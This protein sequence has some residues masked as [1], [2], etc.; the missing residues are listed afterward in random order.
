MMAI[1]VMSAAPMPTYLREGGREGGREWVSEE[2]SGGR[3]EEKEGG[4]AYLP[5]EVGHVVQLFLWEK[6]GGEKRLIRQPREGGMEGGREGGKDVP[7][8]ACPWSR[9]RASLGCDPTDFLS[10]QPGPAFAR[11]RL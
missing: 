1:K 8:T 10:R 6:K 5:D 9:P 7:A 3:E 4:R 2:Y 11:S